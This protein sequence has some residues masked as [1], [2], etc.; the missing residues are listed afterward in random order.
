MFSIHFSKDEMNEKVLGEW[1]VKQMQLIARFF[2]SGNKV[3]EDNI[4]M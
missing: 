3:F 1:K 2:I 4:C